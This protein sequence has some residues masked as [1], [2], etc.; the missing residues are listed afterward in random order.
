MRQQRAEARMLVQD[1]KLSARR[2][3]GRLSTVS[4]TSILPTSCSTAV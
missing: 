2:F 4:G 3:S 1:E